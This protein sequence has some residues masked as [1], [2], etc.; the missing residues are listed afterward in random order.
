MKNCVYLKL[1]KCSCCH[2]RVA[3]D[4]SM[5]TH[6]NNNKTNGTAKTAKVL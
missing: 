5:K 6:D 1:T 2:E 3:N 4:N